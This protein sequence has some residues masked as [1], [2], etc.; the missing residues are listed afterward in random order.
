MKML[1]FSLV[2]LEITALFS[3]D[4][5]GGLGKAWFNYN[6]GA[7]RRGGSIGNE[8]KGLFSVSLNGNTKNGYART[9]F[10]CVY[11]PPVDTVACRAD[12]VEERFA[13]NG[14]GREYRTCSADGK[15]WSSWRFKSCTSGY[16]L[17]TDTYECYR[18]EQDCAS[19]VE[20]LAA[21]G[22]GSYE[23]CGARPTVSLH[24]GELRNL[25]ERNA[26]FFLLEGDC[27]V[28]GQDNVQVAIEGT[29]FFVKAPA[30]CA[31]GTWELH[32]D[33]LS[34]VDKKEVFTV[35]V[36]H[37][38]DVGRR[39]LSAQFSFNTVCPDNYVLVPSLSGYTTDPFC[40]AKYEMK[41]ETGPPGVVQHATGGNVKHDSL[42]ISMAGGTI[43]QG[44]VA[45][46][47]TYIRGS[48]FLTRTVGGFKIHRANAI[49][50]CSDLGQDYNLI[51]N[52]EW[53]TVARNVELVPVNWGGGTVG[54]AQGL[55]IGNTSS[56]TLSASV[57]DN[58][59]CEGITLGASD[60][61]DSKNWHVNRRTFTLSNQQVIWDLAG[62]VLGMD[63]GYQYRKLWS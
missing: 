19:G 14:R 39:S 31:G 38:D 7:V 20:L 57:D 45:L 50:K 8:G 62:N 23:H 53:Q 29:S 5:W 16:A 4:P 52:D 58:K 26:K 54:S 60:T 32:M 48:L 49:S 51:T 34:L 2:L 44:Q 18:Q 61:C 40:V 30:S 12:A 13:S 55:S 47:T 6:V 17:E 37:E 9:G 42:A 1:K 27:S 33:L 3:T 36:T 43:Y 63:K 15:S 41:G 10:R 28:D 46:K 56:D 11:H 21:D 22:T 24:G 25:R 59:A 35:K